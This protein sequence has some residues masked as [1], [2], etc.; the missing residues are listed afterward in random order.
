MH[1]DDCPM[2]R[3]KA[4]EKNI[5]EL[6]RSVARQTKSDLYRELQ[7]QDSEFIDAALGRGAR[8]GVKAVIK[9]LLGTY[10]GKA[11]DM[12]RPEIANAPTMDDEL[13]ETL[14]MAATF[15]ERYLSVRDEASKSFDQ[16]LAASRTSS[17]MLRYGDFAQSRSF[18][19]AAQQSFQRYSQLKA[20]TDSKTDL[21]DSVG[22]V[23]ACSAMLLEA[24]R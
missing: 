3:S 12:L 7:K 11:F 19:Q 6:C 10:A 1:Q 2:Y 18:G 14:R 24:R 21:F 22:E 8:I 17:Q 16:S 15:E 23:K 20:W 9:K 5:D 4:Q 13:K